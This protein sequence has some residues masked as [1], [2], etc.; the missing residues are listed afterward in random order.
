MKYDKALNKPMPDFNA[1]FLKGTNMPRRRT[2]EERLL[3]AICDRL[4][5]HSPKRELSK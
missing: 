2:Q 4:E 3:D 5:Q 1:L